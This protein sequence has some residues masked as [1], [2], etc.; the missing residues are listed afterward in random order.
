M[1]RDNLEAN[2]RHGLIRSDARAIVDKLT[3]AQVIALCKDGN[4]PRFTPTKKATKK[5]PHA[6]DEKFIRGKRG[7]VVHISRN[8]TV[9]DLVKVTG[10]EDKTEE[11]DFLSLP[12]SIPGQPIPD[13]ALP[14]LGNF[15]PAA[16][17]KEAMA[18]TEKHIGHVDFKLSESELGALNRFNE[19][20]ADAMK[21]HGIDRFN[22][23]KVMKTASM[24]R[25][26]IA[27]Y[28]K[29]THDI[30]FN[31]NAFVKVSFIWRN[32]VNKKEHN[33]KLREF[34]CPNKEKIREYIGAHEMA[35]ILFHRSQCTQKV[36]L[37]EA[38][39]TE[40]NEN[41]KIQAISSYAKENCR[42]LFAELYALRHC[43]GE[44]PAETESVLKEVLK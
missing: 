7:G 44:I 10:V 27:G 23:V 19:I 21:V 12:P 17:I 25:K 18:Y 24:E 43:G 36:K 3:D 16:T 30:V 32:G 29:D 2:I 1:D 11:Q 6:A 9:A 40:L 26:V 22:G 4:P 42:E 41:D 39:L 5:N 35:H 15:K 38:L 13:D 33:N 37:C 8:A 31:P 14:Y 20:F 28:R 34:A